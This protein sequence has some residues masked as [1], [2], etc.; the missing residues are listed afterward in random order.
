MLLHLKKHDSNSRL[1]F[2]QFLTCLFLKPSISSAFQIDSVKC[3]RNSCGLIYSYEVNT[4]VAPA[5]TCWKATQT[6]TEMTFLVCTLSFIFGCGNVFIPQHLL[7]FGAGCC[8][9]WS[10]LVFFFFL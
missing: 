4:T 10:F 6:V 8:C 5:V 2:F 1:F 7:C 3:L 9:L